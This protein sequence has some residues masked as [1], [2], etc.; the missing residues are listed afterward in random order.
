VLATH[1][2]FLDPKLGASLQIDGP[3]FSDKVA[4]A[5]TLRMAPGVRNPLSVCGLVLAGANLPMP[6]DES[7]IPAGDGGIL[8]AEAIAGLDL[9][10]MDLVVLSACETGVGMTA[11]G[12]GVLGLQRAFHTA[13]THNVIA[14]LWKVN[15]EAT[16]VLMKL[17]FQKLW[18]EGKAP[19]HALREAQLVLYRHPERV[20][21]LAAVRGPDFSNQVKIVEELAPRPK[22]AGRDTTR[23][24]AGF[25]L[26]GDGTGTRRP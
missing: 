1:G 4:G 11:T 24:W 25:V 9:R 7:G 16:A 20:K 26:S 5:G 14:S 13:G 15:D 10:K 3:L 21:A 2:F 8:T 6:T 18:N 22:P 12:E 19:I 17:F 23:L